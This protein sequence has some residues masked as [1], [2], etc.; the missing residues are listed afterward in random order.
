[1][2]V[3]TLIVWLGETLILTSL[4]VYRGILSL[5]IGLIAGLFAVLLAWWPWRVWVD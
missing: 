5:G 4:G 3:V 1:M 2:L